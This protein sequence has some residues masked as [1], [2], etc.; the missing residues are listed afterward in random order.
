VAIQPKLYNPNSLGIKTMIA[1]LEKLQ[2]AKLL[3]VTKGIPR[4]SEAEDPKKSSLEALLSF[5][6]FCQSLVKVLT[7]SSMYFL[8]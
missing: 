6:E 3:K 5:V 7:Q 2:A 8:S 4:F 1:V